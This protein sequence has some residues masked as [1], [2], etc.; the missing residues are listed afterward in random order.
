MDRAGSDQR[1]EALD[2][3]SDQLSRPSTSSLISFKFKLID[4]RYALVNVMLTILFQFSVKVVAV[5]HQTHTL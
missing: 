4:K 2:G 1:N 3:S 5:G